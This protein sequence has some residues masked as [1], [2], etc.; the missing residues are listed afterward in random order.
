M[1]IVI[2]IFLV[3]ILVGDAFAD[4]AL[5][6]GIFPRRNFSQTHA[7]FTPMAKYLEKELGQ[8]IIVKTTK[9]F[10]TFWKSVQ[11]KEYDIVHYNQYHYVKSH[12]SQGYQIILKN[13]E[14]GT[15]SISG[16]IVVRKNSGIQTLTDLKG[17][18]IIFGG[19]STAMM[20][21]IA[22]KY[23]LKNSGL[24]DKD[25]STEFAK[26]PP[27]ALMALYLG[28][29][30]ASGVGDAV[31]QL[32]I[33]RKKMDTSKLRILSKT[34]GMPHLVW[35]TNPNISLA[36]KQ[37]IQ[38]LLDSLDNTSSGRRVLER[39]KITKLDPA[40]DSEYDVHRQFIYKVLA[41]DYRKK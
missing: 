30:D 13:Q 7:N 27:N 31:L 15:D 21:F 22:A 36:K 19:D 35:A 33:L 24:A 29:A 37:K 26:N 2:E 40:V 3:F 28:Q 8:K 18:K 32:P 17:K 4:D 41:E 9:D 16:A 14:F 39:A 38:S 23:L 20:S 1:L 5:S 12:S 6:M 25:Y 10:S 34:Q 11:N